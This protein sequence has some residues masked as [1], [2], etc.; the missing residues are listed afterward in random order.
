ME[1]API[2]RI[3]NQRRAPGRRVCGSDAHKK[4]KRLTAQIQ[5]ASERTAGISAHADGEEI[6]GRAVIAAEIRVDVEQERR[7]GRIGEA[8]PTPRGVIGFENVA[9]ARIRE[10]VRE[11]DDDS[12]RSE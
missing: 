4:R 7:T 10:E 12:I 6:V 2:E 9:A 1:A 11:V 3:D 5:I 8:D